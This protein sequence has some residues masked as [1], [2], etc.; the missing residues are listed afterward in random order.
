[1][2]IVAFVCA[3]LLYIFIEF[4]F[5]GVA[6]DICQARTINTQADNSSEDG[7]DS[8]KGQEESARETAAAQEEPA[9][10]ADADKEEVC[11]L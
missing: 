3:I 11:Y 10:D 7:R 4:I 5:S 1:M 9:P 8:A 6:N 2:R